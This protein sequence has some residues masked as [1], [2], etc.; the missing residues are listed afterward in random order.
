MLT[1][2][3]L[4]GTLLK[5]TRGTKKA[6]HKLPL[7]LGHYTTNSFTC[8]LSTCFISTD[9]SNIV[10]NYAN[11]ILTFKWHLPRQWDKIMCR[12]PELLKISLLSYCISMCNWQNININCFITGLVSYYSSLV[13]IL[14][15]SDE[16]LILQVNGR[17]GQGHGLVC[18]IAI[19]IKVNFLNG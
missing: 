11:S 3:K 5:I 16:G 13:N 6:S 15:A 18:H 19:N 4:V 2:V 12:F 10:Q 7:H 1:K 8:I 9:S 17:S 14:S